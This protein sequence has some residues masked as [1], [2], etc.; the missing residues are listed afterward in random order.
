MTEKD[1][2][3]LIESY[4]TGELSGPE[5]LEFE[6][7]RLSDPVLAERFHDYQE[8]HGALQLYKTRTALKQKLNVIHA[9]INAPAQPLTPVTQQPASNW[10]VFWNQHFTTMAVAA[11]VAVVTV[12]GS[13]LSLDTVRSVKKQQNARYSELRREVEKIKRSQRALIKGINDQ[14]TSILPKPDVRSASFSGTGF[15][16]S[17]DGYFVT[18]YHVIKDADSVYIENK[19][20]LR[21]KVKEVYQDKAHDLAILK[22][23]DPN[24][25]SFKPLPYALKS[26]TADLGEKVYTLGFPREDMVYGEG[27]LSSRTGFEGDST[28]YQISIPVNPGNSGGPLIDSQGNLIGVISGKQMEQEGAAFAI[29]SAYLKEIIQGMGQDTLSEPLILPRRNHLAGLP[30]TQQLKKLQDYV[31]MVKIYN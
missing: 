5:R 24:F 11:S 23:V 22:I 4:L 30:R 29:K 13:L 14:T 26:G 16:L 6:R 10:R 17:A 25:S 20:G 12:F 3:A 28:A 8:L 18:S 15:V 9:Q 19:Q 1:T 21:Y 7:Q 27:S 2:F 31:F